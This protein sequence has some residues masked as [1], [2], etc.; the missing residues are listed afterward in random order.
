MSI[1]CG[2]D[3]TNRR[4]ARGD[5]LLIDASQDRGKGGCRS[6]GAANECRC[7]HVVDDNIVTDGRDIGVP[8][9]CSVE[10]PALGSCRCGIGI[11][12]GVVGGVWW[13]MIGQICLDGSGLVLTGRVVRIYLVAARC[14]VTYGVV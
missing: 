3:E 1:E 5:T 7:A 2:V 9:T 8:T 12:G 6:R 14:I 10:D 4:L 11:V 13:W